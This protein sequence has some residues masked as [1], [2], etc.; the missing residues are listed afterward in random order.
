MNAKFLLSLILITST[1]F[2]GGCASIKNAYHSASDKVSDWVTPKD[3]KSVEVK[4]AEK[5]PEA[6]KPQEVKPEVKME[7]IKPSDIKN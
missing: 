5:K 2:I 6:V 3:S 1:F 4:P 7:D